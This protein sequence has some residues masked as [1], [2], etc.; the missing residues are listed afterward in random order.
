[1][2]RSEDNECAHSAP[3][4]GS[5]WCLFTPAVRVKSC[6]AKEAGRR[7]PIGR[8]DLGPSLLDLYCRD[9]PSGQPPDEGG[10]DTGRF[11]VARPDHG[12]P[13]IGRDGAGHISFD[14]RKIAADPKGMGERRRFCARSKD[15][16]PHRR[17]RS[18]E[19]RDEE[20][21]KQDGFE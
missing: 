12:R 11:A 1:M 15:C 13:G 3:D 16:G 20:G 14:S 9:S 4:I 5:G 19:N 21:E 18:Q 6:F 8:S 7:E 2:D 17:V 10:Q